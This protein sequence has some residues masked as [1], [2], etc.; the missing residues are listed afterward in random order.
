MQTVKGKLGE[1]DQVWHY[2]FCLSCRRW[3]FTCIIYYYCSDGPFKGCTIECISREDS[4]FSPTFLLNMF[5]ILQPS[6][7]S[8]LQNLLRTEACNNTFQCFYSQC[9]NGN[10][11][12]LNVHSFFWALCEVNGPATAQPIELIGEI[13]V[14]TYKHLSRWSEASRGP[15]LLWYFSWSHAEGLC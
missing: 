6:A 12:F 14:S 9:R 2:L 7:H 15:T 11:S 13:I 4:E 1:R 8:G 10:T 5:L 3:Y